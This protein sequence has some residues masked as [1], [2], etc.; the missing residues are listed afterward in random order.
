MDIVTSEPV[1]TP[2]VN[3][4]GQQASVQGQS[5]GTSF[6]SVLKVE[7]RKM[8]TDVSYNVTFET[9]SGVEGHASQTLERFVVMDTV[10][11]TLSWKVN[12]VGRVQPPPDGSVSWIY[13]VFDSSPSAALALGDSISVSLE[14]SESIWQPSVVADQDD[15]KMVVIAETEGQYVR[16]L[17]ETAFELRVY[18]T[19]NS[20]TGVVSLTVTCTDKANNDG[21]P[22]EIVLP[23]TVDPSLNG[24]HALCLSDSLDIHPFGCRRSAVQGGILSDAPAPVTIHCGFRRRPS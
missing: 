18:I 14:S 7:D 6:T 9:A 16:K 15:I 11:P 21:V 24:K 5:P 4:L 2:N 3:I 8:S 10:A 19:Q 22:L 12:G 17:S 23:I 13:E 20:S 1:Q